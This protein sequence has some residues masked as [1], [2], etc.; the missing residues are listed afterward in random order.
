MDGILYRLDDGVELHEHEHQCHEHGG[1]GHGAGHPKV[2]SQK[3]DGASYRFADDG[4][5]RLVL[6]FAAKHIGG[7]EGCEDGT[8]HED[9]GQT[10]VH[11]HTLV[12]IHGECRKRIAEDDQN[13]CGH[14]DD[15]HDWL[16]DALKKRVSSDG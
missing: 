1:D 2:L 16:A 12:L 14:E 9:G 8:S 5:R 4:E 15:Q 7:D 6:D 13:G 10:D 11:E 3:E